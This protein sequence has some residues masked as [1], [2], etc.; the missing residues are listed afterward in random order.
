METQQDKELV[1]ISNEHPSLESW[2]FDFA[3]YL[4]LPKALRPSRER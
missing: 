2:Q 4:M 3:K 1:R